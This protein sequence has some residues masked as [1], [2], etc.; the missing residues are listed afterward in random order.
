MERILKIIKIILNSKEPVTVDYIADSLRVSNKT[1]RNDLKKVEEYVTKEGLILVK[2]P[3]SGISIEGEEYKRLGLI[4]SI[5]GDV[6]TIEPFCPED[7]KNYI[8]KRLF[9]SDENVTI[10]ELAAE[11][12]VSRV[13]IH[14]DLEY[15]EAWLSEYNLKLLKKTNYGVEIVG[16][17]EAWRKAVANLIAVTKENDEL[18]ELLYKDYS[19]RVDYKTIVKLKELINIDFNQ[20]ERIV[21]NAETKLKFKFS[22]EAFISLIIHIAISIKRL[23]HNKDIN[24]S[25][26]VLLTLMEKEEYSVAVDIADYVQQH[27]KVKLPQSEIGYI[28]LHLLGAKMQQD[29]DKDYTLN[30]FNDEDE[31]SNIM[32]KEIIDRIQKTLYID[33][34]K[35][36]QLINGLILHLRPTINRLK[37][38]LTLRN[39]LIDEIKENYPEIYGATW[40]T[41]TIFQKYLGVKISEEEIGYIA[42]HI[43][44][45]VEREKKP[46]SALVVCTS[47]IG[48]SQLLAVRLKKHFTEIEIVDVVSFISLNEEALKDIDIIIST[49][50]MEADK[51]IITISP[52][53]NQ[54]DIRRLDEFINNINKSKSNKKASLINDEFILLK[55]KYDIK[56]NLIIDVCNKLY[57]NGYVKE[58]YVGSVLERENITCTEVGNGVAIPHGQPSFVNYSQICVVIL[59]KPI[60]WN[61]EYV[62]I[63][64]FICISENDLRKFK[65]MFRSLYNKIDDIEFIQQLRRLKEK[66]EIEKLLEGIEN[67]SK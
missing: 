33:L 22:D 37:Y 3:G 26:D 36:K 1:I 30:L 4:N 42:L 57:K 23:Q 16:Q 43:A 49:V 14:K 27:F 20:L 12:Y 9:M 50:P 8:L 67:D 47:G 29:K 17:E 45:S 53:L 60:K 5:K 19:G 32:S 56:E 39:P 38:G 48:T 28:T 2:K 66:K 65:N 40:M 34:S 52:L 35:D 63:I 62:D 7:R 54:N 10:K 55:E 41:S 59:N 13:T 21:I 15:V 44:A 24:L 25:K 6:E 64:F 51:P 31:L 46:L 18:K 58:E 11:L 61:E